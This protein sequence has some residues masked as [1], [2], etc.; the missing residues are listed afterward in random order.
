MRAHV[1]THA[2][3]ILRDTPHVPARVAGLA[4]SSPPLLRLRRTPKRRRRRRRKVYE[5]QGGRRAGTRRARDAE[6]DPFADEE[7]LHSC[8]SATSSSIGS[9]RPGP[10]LPPVMDGQQQT[11][12]R[13]PCASNNN[14]RALIRRAY[15]TDTTLLTHARVLYTRQLPLPSGPHSESLPA[16]PPAPPPLALHPLNARNNDA[17]VLRA[18]S[19]GSLDTQ[20]TL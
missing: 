5:E 1:R 15:L 16:P 6:T 17:K 18:S 11:T 8:S 12:R 10:R 9:G 20:R 4:I 13:A 19:P 2:H 7:E 3:R 14:K